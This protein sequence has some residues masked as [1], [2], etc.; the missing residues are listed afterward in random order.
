MQHAQNQRVTMVILNENRPRES[1]QFP[2]ASHIFNIEE[3]KVKK[4]FGRRV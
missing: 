4:S 1:F 3:K 2:E